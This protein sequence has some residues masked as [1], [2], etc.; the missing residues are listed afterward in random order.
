MNP[1]KDNMLYLPIKQNYFDE[2]VAGTKKKEYRDISPTTYKKY[3]DCDEEGNPYANDEVL[4][5]E[6]LEYYGADLLMACKDGKFPFYF[7][8]DIK[9]LNLA[10]GYNKERDTAIV[11]VESITAQIP[12][13]RNGHQ[14]RFNINADGSPDITPEGKFCMWQAVF[15][16]GK[17][18]ELHRK[19]EDL[20]V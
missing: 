6:D 2:I 11:E 15:Q 20:S 13:D 14:M 10:V 18:V 5:P 3:L 9:F 8:E 1:T 17:V 7:R 4:S 19:D 16:L 12:N